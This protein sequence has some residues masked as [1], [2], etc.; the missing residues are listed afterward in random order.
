[1]KDSNTSTSRGAS[2]WPA[3]ARRSPCPARATAS[4][5]PSSRAF[6]GHLKEELFHHTTYLSAAAFITA[7]HDY[8]TWYNNDRISTGL[9]GLSPVQYRTQ[10]RTQSRRHIVAISRV[11]L[12]E[13]CRN[14]LRLNVASSIL[15]MHGLSHRLTQDDSGGDL[16]SECADFIV[17]TRLGFYSAPVGSI[18][19]PS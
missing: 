1:M 11:R 12:W 10:A 16:A 15:F 5:T 19:G 9:E 7:L 13:F 17:G 8:I 6:F 3:P 4:T 2:C 18:D 14:N